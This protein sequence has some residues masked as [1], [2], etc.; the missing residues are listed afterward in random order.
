MEVVFSLVLD[1]NTSLAKEMTFFL[2]CSGSIRTF[3]L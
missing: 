3:N 1:R 2:L